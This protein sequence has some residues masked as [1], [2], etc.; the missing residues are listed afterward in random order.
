MHLMVENFF[1]IGD[2]EK[3]GELRKILEK[4]VEIRGKYMDGEKRQSRIKRRIVM[5]QPNYL[6]KAFVLEEFETDPKECKKHIPKY[7]DGSDT[8]LRFGYYV[9]SAKTEKWVWGRVCPMIPKDD[10]ND[11]IEKAKEK[12]FI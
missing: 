12:G 3:E 10:F 1:Y 11:L 9:I 6:R 5:E 7:E 2:L 8:E 4:K